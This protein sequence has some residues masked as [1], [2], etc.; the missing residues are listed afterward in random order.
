MHAKSLQSCL[1]QW[2]PMICSPPG[3]SVYVILQT[4]MLE[5]VFMP[6]SRG[7]SW[8]RDQITYIYIHTYIP[9]SWTSLQ[10]PH[11]IHLG[12]HRA[13]S[14]ASH[15]FSRFPLAIYFLQGSVYIYV[16]PNLPFVLPSPPH[17]VSTCLFSIS[18]FLP[19][20]YVNLN[21]FSRFHMYINMLT[22]DISFSLFD[23]L[24]SVWQTL[25]PST[26]LQMTQLHSF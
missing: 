10:P 6:S 3:S 21:H 23:L 18:A 26:S 13:P 19:W 9:S 4:R 7:S 14:W 2:D 20:K 11:P 15:S 22:Y 17:P 24:C 1:T 16:N 8:P 12:H 25:S 5:W